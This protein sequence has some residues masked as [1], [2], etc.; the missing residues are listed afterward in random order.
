MIKRMGQIFLILTAFFFVMAQ[1]SGCGSKEDKAA[2]TTKPVMA[3]A[4][5]VSEVPAVPSEATTQAAPAK[6][7]DDPSTAVEVDGAKLSK[8]QLDKEMKEKLAALKG[9]IPPESTEA[10][11]GEIRK[12]L[13][14]EFIVR[15]LL[16]REIAK[17]KA[18]ATDKE[19]GEV[20][21]AMKAQLPAGMTMDDL[22]KKNKINIKKMREDI[23]MNLSINKL[24]MQ[25]LGG[26]INVA[27]Q[28][29]SD[30]FNKN[31][32]KFKQPEKVH[33][34]HILVAKAADDTDKI[35][36]EKRTKAEDLRRQLVAG[37]DFASLAAKSSDCPSR[38]NGGDLGFFSRGQMVKP[39]EDAAFSQEK[40]VIG[41]VVETDFGYHII[42]VL[43]HQSAQIA[44][45]DSELK[46]QILAFIE[47]QKQQG[48]FE[49]LVK[50]L[51]A[52]ANIV[53]YGK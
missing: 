15:T 21:E 24:I 16:T 5:T 10:A 46:K 38:Q 36:T 8:S 39:F 6:K 1:V 43:E 30:F 27:D 29:V 12:G 31:Q 19:I 42:Q 45:L 17:R 18:A 47:R 37:T 26:K 50:K 9:Q 3:P 22:L 48:A 40:N 49:G 20:M 25:E 28:E 7:I 41:P 4:P 13:I 53:V 52:G 23:G 32:E 33:A 34:R 11:K 44:K 51:K 14:D 35:K 2:K